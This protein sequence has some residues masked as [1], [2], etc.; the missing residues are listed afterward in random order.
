M[1]LLAKC[2]KPRI[3]CGWNP[4]HAGTTCLMRLI[5]AGTNLGLRVLQARVTLTDTRRK[6]NPL[7]ITTMWT[8]LIDHDERCNHS[9]SNQKIYNKDNIWRKKYFIYLNFPVLKKKQHSKPCLLDIIR[10]FLFWLSSKRYHLLDE[11]KMKET[12]K[13]HL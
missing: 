7:P 11:K 10:C 6:K 9:G 1:Q 12:F 2:G 8:H 4:H 3:Y 13:N 5:P